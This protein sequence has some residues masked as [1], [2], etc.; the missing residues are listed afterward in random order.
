MYTNF[1][2]P[3]VIQMKKKLHVYLDYRNLK[4]YTTIQNNQ[5]ENFGITIFLKETF[6]GLQ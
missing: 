2:F 3:T 6:T 4:A 5:R 1:S